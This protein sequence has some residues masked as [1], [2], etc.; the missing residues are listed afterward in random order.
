MGQV[1]FSSYSSRY[2]NPWC[3]LC[4]V[5]LQMYMF[6]SCCCCCVKPLTNEQSGA[7]IVDTA[8]HEHG[9]A[10]GLFFVRG[11]LRDP[12]PQCQDKQKQVQM[13][14]IVR[15]YTSAQKM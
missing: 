1:L 13:L 8:T 2:K 14:S 11:D 5:L 3:S 4:H 7:Y 9:N 6:K 15:G 12:P 10:H